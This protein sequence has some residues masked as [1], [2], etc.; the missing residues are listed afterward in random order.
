MIDFEI[1]FPADE[2]R[3]DESDFRNHVQKIFYD[4]LNQNVITSLTK[5]KHKVLQQTVLAIM[6]LAF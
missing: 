2:L 1:T 5:F 3:K 6:D 4:N